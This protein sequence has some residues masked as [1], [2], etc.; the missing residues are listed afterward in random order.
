MEVFTAVLAAAGLL[1]GCGLAL[2]T[3]VLAMPLGPAIRSEIWPSKG[4]LAAQ[5][6]I[7][8]ATKPK[9]PPKSSHIDFEIQAGLSRP[10]RWDL[11]RLGAFRG[12]VGHRQLPVAEIPLMYPIAESFRLYIQ[13]MALPQFPLNVLGSVLARNRTEVFRELR[14]DDVLLFKCSVGPAV[15]ITEKGDTEVELIGTAHSADGKTLVWRSTVTVLVLGK[16]RRKGPRPAAASS[17]APPAGTHAAQAQ[18]QIDVFTAP[19]TAGRS[20]GWISGDINPIH[21]HWAASRLFGF[22]RPIAHALYLVGRMEASIRNAGVKPAYPCLLET[23]FK[24]PTLL[25]AKLSVAWQVPEGTD[26][27]YRAARAEGLTVRLLT[28]DSPPKEVIV[29]RLVQGAASGLQQPQR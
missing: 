3:L 4:W 25:P 12:L 11:M 14:A 18:A 26:P 17:D 23:E 5:I 1:L 21:I 29:G 13:A 20:Y 7:S 6:L 22:K 9:S 8:A 10:V 15:K 19:A 27:G 24:R 16:N 2:L 28:S